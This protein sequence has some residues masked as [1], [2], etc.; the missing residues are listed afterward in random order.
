MKII[1]DTRETNAYQF[2]NI[3]P[4]PT[5]L[6]RGLKSGDYSI[7]GFEDRITIERKSQIDLFGSTGK[8]RQR[9]EREFDR[10]ASFDYAAVVIEADLHTII[11]NPPE[12]SAMNPKAVF[13]TLLSWSLKYDVH[14]WPCPSRAFAEKTTYLLL[15]FWLRHENEGWHI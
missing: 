8:G 14:I 10:L 1:V 7:E 2:L 13:R 6:Y 15:E 4:K 5:L 11:K 12:H 9:F 3:T